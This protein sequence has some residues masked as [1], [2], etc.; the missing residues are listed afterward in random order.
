MGKKKAAEGH[1]AYFLKSDPHLSMGR[2]SLSKYPKPGKDVLVPREKADIE[3]LKRILRQLNFKIT[4]QRLAILNQLSRG[5]AHV[6]IEEVHERVKRSFPELGFATVYR[7]L[8][9][10]AVKGYVTEVRMGG[11][12][13]RYELTP[14]SHHD[15]LTCTRCGI[16]V[17]F[18]N[19]DIE[20]LQKQVA[21]NHN[22]EL[23][24][25]VL[26]LYGIC[27]RCK[28]ISE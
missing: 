22:F 8:K 17:E 5:Q 1:E 11:L 20:E 13:A 10:L 6:T 26:E 23:T 2:Q 27:P 21:Y 16:I 18:E 7:M 25:H 12:P 3:S 15:H 28:K 9:S 4:E 24:G 14:K 19:H